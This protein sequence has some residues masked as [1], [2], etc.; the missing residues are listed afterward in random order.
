MLT[1]RAKA[2]LRLGLAGGGT[3]VS[4]Y[5]DEHGGSVLNVTIDRSALAS[6]T[7]RDD[8][9][10][11]FHAVDLGREDA[12]AAEIPLSTDTGLALHRAAYNRMIAQFNGGRPLALTLTTHVDCPPGSGLGSSSAL[13]VAMVAALGEVLGA[14]LG[15]YDMARLAFDIERRDLGL[16]G[17]RQDQYAATFGGFNFIEFG[18]DERV[19]VNP[20][21]VK[22]STADE[23]EASL[24]LYYMGASRDSAA[25]IDAQIA[26]VAAGGRS[27]E[28]MHTLKAEAIAM[29]EAVLLGR[30][31]QIA[32][33]LRK[34]WE[35]KKAT[36]SA[37]SNPAIERAFAVAEANGALAGK[38]C[39]AGG[40]GYLV[41]V[42]PPERR[43]SLMRALEAGGEGVSELFHFTHEGVSV[44]RAP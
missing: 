26:D 24:A 42:V 33:L 29:K 30:I 35:A 22:R 38:V 41:F 40:G 7:L 25:I 21:R 3:D 19:I 1:V 13:V 32:Q 39:G 5:C 6:V 37:V 31:D 36:S 10:V 44:W 12:C 23:L 15:E 8:G 27:L 18:A 34:G 11:A 9:Q 16:A 17:G 43:P 28:A 14:P 4:P 2:P 20:L